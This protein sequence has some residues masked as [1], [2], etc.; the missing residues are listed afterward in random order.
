[1]GSEANE[2]LRRLNTLFW[3]DEMVEWFKEIKFLQSYR[4]C[5]RIESRNAEEHIASL[6][7][8]TGEPVMRVCEGVKREAGN[9]DPSLTSK[10][11]G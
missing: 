10:K 8:R 7:G 1:M 9:K 11:R 5:P 4:F 6:T 2:S 3:G